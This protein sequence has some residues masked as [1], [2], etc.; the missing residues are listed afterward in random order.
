MAFYRNDDGV[1][2]KTDEFVAGGTYFLFPEDHATYEYPVE[3]WYWFDSDEEAN[4]FFK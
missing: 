3:G 2:T 1:I 4:E